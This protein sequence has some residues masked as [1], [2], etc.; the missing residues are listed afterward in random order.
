M[1]KNY[2]LSKYIINVDFSRYLLSNNRSK[3]ENMLINSEKISETVKKSDCNSKFNKFALLILMLVILLIPIGFWFG[4][5]NDREEYRNEAVKNVAAAWGNKQVFSSPVMYFEEQKDKNTERIYFTLNNYS[6]DV[7]IKTEVRQKG[8]YK[9]PV[10]VAD[11]DMSGDFIN[12]F[13]D[14][15]KKDITL[16]FDVKDSVG[17]IS[18]PSLKLNNDKELRLQD[19]K[20]IFKLAEAGESIPFEIKY[21]IRGIDDLY[22]GLAGLSNKITV[23]GDWSN[24][25]FVGNFLP[26]KRT[27]NSGDFSAEWSIPKIATANIADNSGVQANVG[28]SLLMPVDNYRMAYR[29]LKYA[30]LFIT[31]TFIS[32]SIFEI[33]SKREKR[34]HPLQ[35]LLLGGAMLIFYLLLVSISELM[36]FVFAYIIAGIMTISLLG[37]YTYCVIT[38]KQDIRFTL[39]IMGLLVLLYTFLYI[40]LML[41]DLA[42]LTGSLGLFVIIALIMY[43]T[44]NV[45]WYD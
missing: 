25:S 5:I 44:R 37:F 26:S 10:Y 43:A 3:G 27:V 12:N 34:I 16:T 13:G 14:L 6:A 17:F 45:D 36:P 29:A 31:L 38:K 22:V 1:S 39:L 11:V 4:I 32:Y 20:Y 33:T 40:L 42:L 19:T 15:S 9:V 30:F 8:I 7:K 24:P 18:E 2:V 35:Y 41:Q 21:R 28:V 23:S